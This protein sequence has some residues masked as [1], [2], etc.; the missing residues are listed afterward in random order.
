METVTVF[1]PTYNRKK[2]LERLYNSLLSQTDKDFIWLVIDDGSTDNTEEYINQLKKKTIEFKIEY[3]Y[4]ENG[5]LHTGYNE[6]I[7]HM[8]T[9]LCICCDSDDWLPNDC[10]EIIKKV[11]KSKKQDN[12]AGIIGLDFTQKNEIIGNKLPD[13]EEYVDMNELYIKGKLIGDKKLVVRTDLYKSLK[14]IETINNE[15]NFNPNYLNVVLS[16]K[17]NWIPLNH[18]L[19]FV[20]YQQDGMTH[21]IFKQYLNSPNSFIELRKLYLS[22][23]KATLIFKVKHSIHYDA[24]C[25]IAKKTSNIFS[26]ESPDRILTT[27]LFP[28]GL[29]LYLF[30]KRKGK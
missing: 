16:E 4:K 9:E 2:L 12:C 15:K 29:A 5:G 17:Y 25:I 19:C 6:A 11:W 3:H 14:P 10:I 22:L 7:K 21:G 18:N 23:N 27:V 1:T 20:E 8:K 30:I 24:E 13:D 26:S 28:F